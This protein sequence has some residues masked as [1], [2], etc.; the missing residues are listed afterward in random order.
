LETDA[1]RCYDEFLTQWDKLYKVLRK[2]PEQFAERDI[3]LS[4]FQWVYIL[5]TNRC[6]GSN[7]LGIYQMTPFADFLNHENVDTGFDCVNEKG[8]SIYSLK[9]RDEEEERDAKRRHEEDQH[10]FIT[11]M[12]KDLLECEIELRQK[13]AEQGYET[14]TEE[15]K[16]DQKVSYELMRA[17]AK[18]LDDRREEVNRILASAK[19][20]EAKIGK[21]NT[22][23]DEESSGL[24]SDNDV[25]LIVE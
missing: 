19:A 9:E 13:M 5:L 3:A 24:E 18:H 25:D 4:K 8:E 15:A 21:T 22:A 2:Y 16:A 23:Q 10:E 14:Q 7:F 11:H 12:K 6:F 17:S 1:E 20:K